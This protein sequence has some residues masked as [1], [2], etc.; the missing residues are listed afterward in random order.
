MLKDYGYDAMVH[1]KVFGITTLR[2][3]ENQLKVM[4]KQLKIFAVWL[5]LLEGWLF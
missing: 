1:A 5:K 4:L 3:E 2:N